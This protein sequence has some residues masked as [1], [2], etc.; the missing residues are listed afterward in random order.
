MRMRG[1]GS[2]SGLARGKHV[3]G[4]PIVTFGAIVC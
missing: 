3:D 4:G 2:G 1:I